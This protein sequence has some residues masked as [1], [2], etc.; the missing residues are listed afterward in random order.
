MLYFLYCYY[1]CRF[2]RMRYNRNIIEIYNKRD[3]RSIKDWIDL[4]GNVKKN[5]YI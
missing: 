5:I 4:N 1:F 2:C 3:K